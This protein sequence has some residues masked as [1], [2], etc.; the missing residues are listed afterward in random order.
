M[1]SG[2]D[3]TL[4]IPVTNAAAAAV[5][6]TGAAVVWKLM[7]NGPGGTVRITKQS[8]GSGITLTTTTATN[9]TINITLDPADTA[10]LAGQYYHECQVTDSVADVSTVFTGVAIINA[11]GV[12]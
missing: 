3:K 6:L 4:I 11:D 12:T 2:D 5:S 8:G 10:S 1:W 7:D 9:D